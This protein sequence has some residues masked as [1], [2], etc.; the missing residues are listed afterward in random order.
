MKYI[1]R[2][3]TRFHESLEEYKKEEIFKKF[4]DELLEKGNVESAIDEIVKK[5]IK[6]SSSETVKGANDISRALEELRN[7][8]MNKFNIREFLR[9]LRNEI[10]EIAK[11]MG[12]DDIIEK[13]KEGSSIKS[14][15]SEMENK[16]VPKEMKT[17]IERKEGYEKIENF[18][19]KY[20]FLFNKGEVPEYEELLEY[21]DKIESL[22]SMIEALKS[23]DLEKVDAEK[24]KKF[25]GEKFWEDIKLL[26]EIKDFIK[27]PS[28]MR[29]EGGVLKLTPRAI[30]KIGENALR[31]IFS[32][33]K[34]SRA[35]EHLSSWRGGIETRYE[36]S[37]PYEDD[38]FSEI[39]IPGTLFR[40]FRRR[41]ISGGPP[42]IPEDFL[43]YERER[44][45]RT[46]LA[47]LLD[48]SWSMSWNNKFT[49]AKKVAC[50]LSHLIRTK[51]PRDNLYI[52][53]FYTTAVLLKEDELL[54]TELNPAE[55]FTNIQHALQLAQKVLS[56]DPNYNKQI[57]LITD[58]QPTAYCY[59]GM[60]HIEWPVFGISPN[61]VRE[62][63]KEVK[64]VTKKGIK[65]NTF[66]VDDNPYLV[67]LVDE[68]VRINGGRVFYT[69]PNELGKYLLVDYISRKRKVIV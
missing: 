69:T 17:H 46:S 50:A 24:L 43:I 35:G 61:A 4:S 45:V 47:L 64:A 33:L 10:S 36:E 65:I 19:K 31:D 22:N 41:M 27:N 63:I 9:E 60:I 32:V 12:R 44:N 21:I 57:I 11:K 26:K 68:I 23:G 39:N 66:M 59:K 37:R 13:L 58:G 7:S 53:G 52:I 25:V 29:E 40:S 30:R 6:F 16:S 49:A 14:A 55:P 51:F 3:R 2:S 1:Y 48:M 42:L 67:R 62:T 18:K 56:S 38:E 54:Y 34:N 8:I 20:P 15:I 5:G 28:I